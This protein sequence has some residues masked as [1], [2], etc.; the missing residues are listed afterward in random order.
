MEEIAEKLQTMK[1]KKG[2]NHDS[3]FKFLKKNLAAKNMNLVISASKI[4]ALLAKWMKEDFAGG[5]KETIGS[6]M[7]K[8]KEKRPMLVKEL[9]SYSEFLKECTSL[10]EI[11]DE[12]IP[13]I[14]NAAPG[15]R[16][17][18]IKFISGMVPVTYMDVLKR[19]S[20]I[21]IEPL[22]KTL[23]DKDSGVREQSMRCVGF[24][25]GR[26]GA[27]ALDK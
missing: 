23:D 16:V 11:Q 21:Y 18:T 14:T 7:L 2:G 20:D 6:V 4:L 17:G 5:A 12:L 10:E 1:V 15:V 3:L 24:I 26:L 8:Y 9:D 19:V 25:R 27:D 22:L 13:C